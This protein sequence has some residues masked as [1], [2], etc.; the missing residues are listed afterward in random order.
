MYKG[1]LLGKDINEYM[2][3]DV[4]ANLDGLVKCAMSTLMIAN[5]LHVQMVVNVLMT[6]LT[7]LVFANKDTLARIVNIKLTI[8]ILTLVK[9]EALVQVSLSFGYKI[10]LH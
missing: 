9:M 1:L 10:M 8:V 5:L 7:T 3:T 2:I 6:L 4:F